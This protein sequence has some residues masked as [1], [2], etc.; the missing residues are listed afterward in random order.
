MEK[1]KVCQNWFIV[2]VF[3]GCFYGVLKVWVVYNVYNMF[4]GFQHDVF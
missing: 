3:V 4:L 1:Q 2:G